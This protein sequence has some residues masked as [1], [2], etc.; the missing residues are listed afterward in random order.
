MCFVTFSWVTPDSI[1]K[2][3]DFKKTQKAKWAE[4][5]I[6]TRCN[7][8]CEWCYLP[9]NKKEKDMKKEDFYEVLNILD[10]SNI[11]QITLS[12]GEPLLH[13]NI[14]EFV[15]MIKKKGIIVHINSNGWH[16]SEIMAKK[17]K[18]AGL[19]QIQMNIDSLNPKKHNNIRGKEKSFVKVIDAFRNAKKY[20]I[21]TVVQ[22]VL[23]K[24]NVGEITDIMDFSRNLGINR[25][26][27][28]DMTPSGKGKDKIQFA[29]E[30]Y[31]KCLDKLAK[32]AIN[33]GAKNIIS[34]EPTFPNK[35]YNIP[36]YHL[37]CPAKL[38]LLITIDPDGNVKYCCTKDCTLYN[39]FDY[40]DIIKK[41]SEM[42]NL[43]NKEI[44]NT[45][46]CI[47]CKIYNS[48]ISGCPSRYVKSKDIQCIMN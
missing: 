29:P 14:E 40:P 45:K 43:A 15:R 44:L 31:N 6:T 17:L 4:I 5:D 37:P 39:I 30:D 28:W 19:S 13:P 48:C 34:Y 38:G 8:N 42:I 9:V 41:H 12:G 3:E 7:F 24:E 25:I 32:H 23:T 33:L 46:D 47:D 35:K 16:L 10:K 11:T 21:T 20:G 1:N 26:R 27:M 18:E 22:T 36:A 2:I